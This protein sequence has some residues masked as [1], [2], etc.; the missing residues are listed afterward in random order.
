MLT[1]DRL[2]SWAALRE[3]AA[4]VKEV[5]NRLFWNE[6]TGR[7]FGWWEPEIIEGSDQIQD[8]GA[9][10][11]Y[12]LCDMYARIKLLGGDDAWE[13]LKGFLAWEEDAAVIDSGAVSLA[14]GAVLGLNEP[15]GF[16]ELLIGAFST[17]E[18]AEAATGATLNH[19]LA[20]DNLVVDLT[21]PEPASISLLALG[22]LFLLRRRR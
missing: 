1:G 16:D 15:I 19:H 12:A 21:I 17:F 6:K 2:H 11:G 14:S 9:M 13:R 5:G 10:V 22:T 18:L 20:I 7:F 8:G 3:H 4:A